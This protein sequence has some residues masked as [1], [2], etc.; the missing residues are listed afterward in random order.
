VACEVTPTRPAEGDARLHAG[1]LVRVAGSHAEV[2]G[3]YV[4]AETI[5]TIDATG[6]LVAVSS[7]PPQRLA[8]A[9]G[10]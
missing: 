3:T 8:P 6:Y 7:A 2:A 1:R 4:L 10:R 5:H 9:Q